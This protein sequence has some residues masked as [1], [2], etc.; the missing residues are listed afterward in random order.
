ME[1][2]YLEHGLKEQGVDVHECGLEEV[3]GEHGYLGVLTVGA[4][5]VAV[6]AVE[7]H[8]VAGVPVLDYLQAAVDLAAQV[9]GGE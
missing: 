4:G 5:E 3:Q 1:L 8:C 9:L 7:D 2:G 6:L